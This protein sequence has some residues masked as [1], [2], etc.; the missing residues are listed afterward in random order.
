VTLAY[1]IGVESM[2]RRDYSGRVSDIS[3][4]VPRWA[5]VTLAYCIGVE[6]PI[7]QEIETGV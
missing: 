2:L 4:G 5:R 7:M 3:K 1:C 6:G